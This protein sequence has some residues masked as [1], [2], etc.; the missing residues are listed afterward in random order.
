MTEPHG[1]PKQYRPHDHSWMVG[2]WVLPLAVA[3]ALTAVSGG[4]LAIT[5][6]VALV[7]GIA[8]TVLHQRDRT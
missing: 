1:V 3:A 6:P 8:A 4:L 7:V 5:L 2:A